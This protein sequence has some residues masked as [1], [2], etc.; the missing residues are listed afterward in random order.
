MARKAGIIDRSHIKKLKKIKDPEQRTE[1]LKYLVASL[2][3]LKAMDF[4]SN[5]PKKR[6]LKLEARL[7]LLSAKIKL[8]E[9]S[10]SK[11]DYSAVKKLIEEI[12][13]E[14]SKCSAS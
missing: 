9:T 8:L 13:E 7:S 5:C 3:K 4:E 6:S 10:H 11:Q 2:L 1:G 14:L 12:E